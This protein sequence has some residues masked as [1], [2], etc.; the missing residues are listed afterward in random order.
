MKNKCIF[1]IITIIITLALSFAVFAHSGKTDSSGGHY[2][3][4]N[5]GYHYHHGYP[6]HGHYDMDGDGDKDCP[7]DFDDKTNHDS[8]G[9]SNSSTSENDTTAQEKN[10]T[11]RDIIGEILE[12]LAL[13]FILFICGVVYIV[14]L[15]C[16]FVMK[17]IEFLVEKYCKTESKES[18]LKKC[19]T[20]VNVIAVIAVIIMSTIVTIIMLN[21]K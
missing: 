15:S 8:N 21:D 12:I 19:N 20:T 16:M 2:D 17:P 3:H 14:P 9:S 11:A 6:A 18:I 13:S 5:G 7:Y 1:A 4:K 10:I